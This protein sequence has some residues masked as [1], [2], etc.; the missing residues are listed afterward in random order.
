LL[1]FAF[2]NR[3]CRWIYRIFIG[4]HFFYGN[5][6]DIAS[7]CGLICLY[8]LMTLIEAAERC[9]S[10]G[11][12]LF[13]NSALQHSKRNVCEF[14]ISQDSLCRGASTNGCCRR[15]IC[16][17]IINPQDELHGN[18]V[19]G[20][21]ARLLAFAIFNGSTGSSLTSIFY[22]ETS[23]NASECGLIRL[24]HTM[25]PAAA[26]ERLH[27]QGFLYSSVWNVIAPAF[28]QIRN[29]ARFAVSC[30]ERMVTE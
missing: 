23:V 11:S 22:G 13:G 6:S 20:Q 3:W 7:E 21:F 24:Y 14:E 27:S 12:L 28:K 9:H 30:C 15:I 26:N 4:E 8:H 16:M 29:F 17:G 19:V 1:A 18:N 10:Q 2:F 5:T 25:A